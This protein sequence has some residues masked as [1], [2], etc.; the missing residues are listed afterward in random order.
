[1]PRSDITFDVKTSK[2]IVETLKKD[3]I[4]ELLSLL[5]KVGY[6]PSDCL[7]LTL[8]KGEK[9]IYVNLL[10][11][12]IGR[13]AENIFFFLLD[14]HQSKIKKE[15]DEEVISKLEQSMQK[16]LIWVVSQSKH[17]FLKRMLAG[18]YSIKVDDY[19]FFKEGRGEKPMHALHA[20]IRKNFQ[21]N[22]LACI[23]CLIA[24]GANPL[25]VIGGETVLDRVIQL[26]AEKKAQHY[27]LAAL[28]VIVKNIAS[29]SLE[30]KSN[31]FSV[32]DLKKEIPGEKIIKTV[33]ERQ[34][35]LDK[36]IM[37]SELKTISTELIVLLINKNT[38][39]FFTTFLPVLC[40]EQV[41]QQP[42]FKDLLKKSGWD[43]EQSKFNM[44]RLRQNFGDLDKFT[45][46]F[47]EIFNS[48]CIISP[49]SKAVIA[50]TPHFFKPS[51]SND[52]ND[53]TVQPRCCYGPNVA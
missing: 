14:S 31:S 20:L 1:M 19:A 18:D 9:V 36:Q 44:Q 8:E 52:A 13:N 21:D 17:I 30:K 27:A 3:D 40:T 12:A 37:S 24:H 38:K 46:A 48:A 53:T 7:T 35:L 29:T 16:A 4:Q 45:K 22:D 47:C 6:Q 32:S 23:E 49:K 5:N 2:L 50:V 51:N 43:T 42:E 39:E 10:E 11:Q 15:E 26:A 34:I 41:Q 33:L 25:Q 28:I